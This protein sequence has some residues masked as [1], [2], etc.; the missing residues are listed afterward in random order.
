MNGWI[1]LVINVVGF[2]GWGALA[3]SIGMVR[4]AE[5]LLDHAHDAKVDTMR[6]RQETQ[7]YMAQTLEAINR[8]YPEHPRH[9][10]YQSN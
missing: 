2:C 10:P 9:D 6:I 1:L 4:E 5:T 8:A 7:V 3:L